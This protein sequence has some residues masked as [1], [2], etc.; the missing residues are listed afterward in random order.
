MPRNEQENTI[1]IIERLTALAALGVSR[2]T[3]RGRLERDVK[4]LQLL[5]W[6]QT[7]P[8]PLRLQGWWAWSI[9]G[10]MMPE[11]AVDKGNDIASNPSIKIELCIY[12]MRC[13]YTWGWGRGMW[14]KSKGSMSKRCLK[15]T[16]TVRQEIVWRLLSWH[17][18]VQH[19]V[20]M[21]KIQGH[22]G[23]R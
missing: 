20:F 6:I 22:Y 18:D 11:K 17:L 1:I 13:A 14:L 12:S 2:S 5:L 8:L 21:E 9:L 10:F 15:T 4:S 7:V 19:V 3:L 23:S 16:D